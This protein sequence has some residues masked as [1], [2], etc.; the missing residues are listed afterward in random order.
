LKADTRSHLPSVLGYDLVKAA[1]A[2]QDKLIKEG[3]GKKR[4]AEEE[5]IGLIFILM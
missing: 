3:R 2:T 5:T 4:L 1:D